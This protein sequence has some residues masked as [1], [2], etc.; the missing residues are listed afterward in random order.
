MSNTNKKQCETSTDKCE[1][2]Q[3]KYTQVKTVYARAAVLLLAVNFCLTGYVLTSMMEIQGG[4]ADS[5][6]APQT[7]SVGSERADGPS[8]PSAPTET[9]QTLEKEDN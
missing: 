7:L 4:Q 9:P 5:S 6:Q 2:D 1:T 8:S 3:S